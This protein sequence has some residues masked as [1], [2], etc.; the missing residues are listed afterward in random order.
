[1]SSGEEAS[2]DFLHKIFSGIVSNLAFGSS[3]FDYSSPVS[4]CGASPH[5]MILPRLQSIFKTILAN[6]ATGAKLLYN[7]LLRFNSR[8]K[9][10][11]ACAVASRTISPFFT[12]KIS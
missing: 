8:K 2:L 1:M 10:L 12:I 5:S 9:E 6:R 3:L 4:F 11:R 7:F